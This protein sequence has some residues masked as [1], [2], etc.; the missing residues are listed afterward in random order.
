MQGNLRKN[1]VLFGKNSAIAL[2]GFKGDRSGYG[3]LK[4]NNHAFL[5]TNHCS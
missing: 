2:P 4:E 5:L 3:F 1:Y